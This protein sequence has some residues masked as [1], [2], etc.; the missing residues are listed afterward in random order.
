MH[1]INIEN[2]NVAVDHGLHYLLAYGIEEKSRNGSVLVAPGPVV[3]VYN[4]PRQRVLFSPLRDANP[5]FHLMESL[6]ML[7]G[8]NDIKFPVQ[9]NKRFAEYSDDGKTSWGAYGWRWREFFGYDQLDLIIKELI[10]N[11]QSRRCVLSMWN[12]AD[13]WLGE[14]LNDDPLEGRSD[15]YVATNGGK[16]VPCNTHAYFDL[17][18]GKL[19]MTVCNRS[20]DAVWGAYGANAV[21]FSILQEYIAEQVGVP[22]GVYRQISNNFHAYLDVYSREKLAAIA[23]DAGKTNLYS[24]WPTL[25]TPYPLSSNDENWVMDLELFLD[26]GHIDYARKTFFSQIAGP[27]HAAWFARKVGREESAMELLSTM[28]N[29]DWRFAAMEW[30]KRRALGSSHAA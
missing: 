3:T 25:T 21:H 29:C 20:N 18:N 28:P 24:T 7:S 22:M 13:M 26:K 1:T 6:W 19:N 5:Y 11:P 14:S 9:F 30:A 4:N 8:R 17:R 12:G 2:V 15:L 23:D 16:D 10:E 27:M